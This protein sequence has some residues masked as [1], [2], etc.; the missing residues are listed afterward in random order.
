MTAAALSGAS[1]LRAKSPV[2]PRSVVMRLLRRSPAS[3]PP[4]TRFD[5][6]RPACPRRPRKHFGER[7]PVLA[8][9]SRLPLRLLATIHVAASLVLAAA[10]AAPLADTAAIA[11]TAVDHLEPALVCRRHSRR[12]RRVVAKRARGVRVPCRR[13]LLQHLR[14]DGAG[15]AVSRRGKRRDRRLSGVVGSR[16]AGLVRSRHI[17]AEGT[18]VLEPRLLERLLKH[19]L[20]PP[21]AV[22]EP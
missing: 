1:T 21:R 16:R 13:A 3:A 6:A 12:L 14:W 7:S 20:L 19:R 17:V 8:H 22:I 11:L 18:L 4:T 15:R 5:S 2:V 10:I 9:P